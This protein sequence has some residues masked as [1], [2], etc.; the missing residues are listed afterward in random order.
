MF[1]CEHWM[2]AQGVRCWEQVV[3]FKLLEQDRDRA[4]GEGEVMARDRGWWH[5][6]GEVINFACR[7]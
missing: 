1:L 5:V 6:E 2:L 7:R 3:N 4:S